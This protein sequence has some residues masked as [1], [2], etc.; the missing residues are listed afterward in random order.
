MIYTVTPSPALDRTIEIERMVE[1]DTIRVL[2]ETAYAGGTGISV[3]RVIRSWG[4]VAPEFI[5]GHDG[6]EVRRTPCSFGEAESGGLPSPCVR[7]WHRDRYDTG[8]E[9][10]YAGGCGKT[11]A[12]GKNQQ[13]LKKP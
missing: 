12:A 10:C 8:N 9:T 3:C 2:N 6:L 4:R 1:E 7:H 13:N 5:G 11:D